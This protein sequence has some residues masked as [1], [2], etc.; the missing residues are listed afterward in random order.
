MSEMTGMVACL[1]S[2]EGFSVSENYLSCEGGQR[3]KLTVRKE[4]FIMCGLE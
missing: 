2:Q 3:L 4:T 1:D